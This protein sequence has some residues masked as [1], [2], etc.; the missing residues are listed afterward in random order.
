MDTLPSVEEISFPAPTAQPLSTAATAT[1]TATS[2][3]TSTNQNSDSNNIDMAEPPSSSTSSFTT[4]AA[5]SLDIT[6]Q[7]SSHEKVNGISASEIAA[8]NRLL[9]GRKV[10]PSVL[11]AV[12][13]PSKRP[14]PVEDQDPSVLNSVAKNNSHDQFPNSTVVEGT[15]MTTTRG[16]VAAV[17]DNKNKQV[18]KKKEVEADEEEE[19]TEEEEEEEEQE[20]VHKKQQDRNGPSS[21]V[22]SSEANARLKAYNVRVA[23]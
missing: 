7:S 16:V 9:L 13:I 18:T 15:A 5:Q 20:Q 2:I 22:E 14:L 11:E 23:I 4:D 10:S 19:E 21:T 6:M 1:A 17:D 8:L 3:P 12:V